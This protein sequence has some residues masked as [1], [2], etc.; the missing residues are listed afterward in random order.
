MDKLG[1]NLIFLISLPRSGSTMLQRILAGHPDIHT[2]PEPWIM[3]HPL[4][5]LKQSGIQTEYEAPLAYKSSR[6]YLANYGGE[7]TYIDALRS[8]AKVLYE[9]PINQSGKKFFLDKTP[10]YFY[11]IPELIQ[12]FPEAKYIFLFRNPLSVLSSILS[13]WYRNDVSAFNQSFNHLDTVRG[14]KLLLQGSKLKPKHSAIVNYEEFVKKPEYSLRRLCNQINIKYHENILDYSSTQPGAS[15]LGDQINVNTHSRP[16]ADS[17]N[18]WL[19]NISI[20]KSLIEFT[21]QY[22]QQLGEETVNQ[23]GYD[24]K[25][26]QKQL[27]NINT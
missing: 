23:A 2:A 19:K 18:L 17:T 25:L 8:M 20:N 24:Y 13:T 26:L 3:L 11:V 27:D 7:Q 4:Y 9:K 15:T 6:S 16:V 14:P 12:V 10:R 21:R 22:L 1:S 5:A